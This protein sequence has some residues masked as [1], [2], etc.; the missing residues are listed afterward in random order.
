LWIVQLPMREIDIDAGTSGR[1]GL[2]RK[3]AAIACREGKR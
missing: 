3:A 1:V 2:Q